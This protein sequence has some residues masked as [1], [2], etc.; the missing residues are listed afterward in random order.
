MKAEHA[1][2]TSEQ[3]GYPTGSRLRELQK[4]E[5]SYRIGLSICQCGVCCGFYMPCEECLG[6]TLRSNGI[7]LD[8]PQNRSRLKTAKD[9]WGLQSLLRELR[10]TLYV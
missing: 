4:T 1:S 6:N 9:K 8:T 10:D 5:L 7:T 3:R 2:V